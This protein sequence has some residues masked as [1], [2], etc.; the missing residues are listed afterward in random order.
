MGYCQIRNPKP[1]LYVKLLLRFKRAGLFATAVSWLSLP[2][3]S[4]QVIDEDH[5]PTDRPIHIRVHA[6]QVHRDVIPNTIFGSFLEP[7]GRS[8]YGG[9]WAELLENPSFEEG[10]W[11]AGAI[12]KMV[13]ERPELERAS[14]LDLPLPWE[15]LDARQGNRYEP[16]RGDAANSSQSLLVMGLPQAEVGI[17]QRIYLP[18]HRTLA[19]RGSLFIKHQSGAAQVYISIRRRNDPQQVLADATIEA[20]K[21][22]WTK[23]SFELTIKLGQVDALQPADFVVAVRDDS[24]AFIDQLSLMP[25]DNVDGMDAEVLKLAK[26]L[27]TPLVRY[28]GNFTS[29]YHWKNGIGPADQRSS[30]SNLAWNIPEYNTF[31]TEEFLRFCELIGAQPQVALNL[32]SGM[33]QEAGDWVKYVNARWGNK[34]GGLLWE[35]G[36]E[37]WGSWNMGYPTRD[38]IGTR[39]E[40][41]SAAIR[42]VDPTARLIATGADEDFYHDWNAVQLGTPP[43]T[44]Q[45]LSTHFVVTDDQVQMSN[46]SNDFVA[47]SAFA[48]PIGLERRMKEMTEQI[49]QSNHKD[50]Q[51][52]FTEWL[53]V[54]ADHPAPG[55][56]NMGGAIDTA[57]FLNMLMR[58]ADIVPI[59]DMTGILEFGGIWKKREQVYGAPG[60]WVLRSY[61]EEKPSRLVP[62]DSDAPQYTVDHG[63]TRL[64]HIE[65]V[66][67]LEVVAAEGQTP[68]E[69]I[70]FCVNR[71]LTR[72]YRATIQV[73]GFTPRPLAE[74]KTIAAPS[75]YTEN[76]EMEPEAVKAVADQISV[77]SSFE[78]VFPRAGVV[79]IRLVR[80][81]R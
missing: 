35:L 54:A 50:A 45:Y 51:I 47:L 18:V 24:R 76:D 39:T 66:P 60:Y 56:R 17:R 53:F 49:Q 74:I 40:A 21:E 42:K 34:Q 79:V 71:N 78:H 62:T 63:V 80:R 10:L 69:L 12:V 77:G 72:D 73:D 27:H 41:F 2:M 68:D 37:L 29:S 19:Y 30:Q 4:G 20:N 61:A 3:A 48:L 22:V 9:L 8:T 31:G 11:S 33:P 1:E 6:D 5:G 36:N 23:Y 75:I 81:N 43:A 15:P 14:Q 38:Q 64:P 7:I 28:G 58:N 55:F 26:D 32:G 70:L 59:S 44:F 16:E 65:H 25:A 46:P 57:G 13:Q 67:W 52:A